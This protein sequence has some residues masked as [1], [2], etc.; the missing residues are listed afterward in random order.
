MDLSLFAPLFARPEIRWVSLQYG[1][2]DDLEAQAAA[3]GAPLLIDRQV[4][5]LTDMDLF[6]AQLLPWTW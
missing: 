4:D 1:D 5:Q 6:A 2:H 3:A